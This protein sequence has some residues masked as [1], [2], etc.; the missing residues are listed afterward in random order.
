MVTQPNWGNKI[1]T[2]VFL[3]FTALTLGPCVKSTGY[4]TISEVSV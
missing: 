2:R 3:E 4:E 1:D